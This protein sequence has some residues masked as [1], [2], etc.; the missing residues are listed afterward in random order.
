MQLLI[1]T[2]VVDER[3]PYLSFF[4]AWIRELAKHTDRIEVICLKKGEYSLPENVRVHSLGK[5]SSHGS[6]LVVRAQYVLRFFGLIWGLRKSYDTVL[7]HMNQEY[8]LL[9][10]LLWLLEGKRIFMWRNHYA[11]TSITRIATTLCTKVFCTSRYSYTARF[12]KTVIMPVGVDT[13][14]FKP[15][16]GERKPRTLVS[17]GRV[18]PSK[19]INLLLEALH[20]LH[21]QPIPVT[22]TIY[23]DALPGDIEYVESLKE[24]V[25]RLHL[26]EEVTFR[27]GVAH[28]EAPGVFAAHEVAINLSRS[29][30]LD[31]T[32]F[33]AAACECLVLAVSDDYKTLVDSRLHMSEDPG[34]IAETLR[35]L[36][37]LP[38][39]ERA[40]MGQA[41]RTMVE[42]KH[43]LQS[44]GRKLIHEMS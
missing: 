41:L 17:F 36:L 33:E 15:G 2:Q 43:S 14:M 39:D 16:L 22:T 21:R 35:A 12:R 20:V 38:A 29:G 42:E 37:A 4:V 18:A 25:T 6:Y 27:P 30:M 10:G 7:V 11:G 26:Q 3:D 13:E 34:E 24:M 8:V 32:I 5:E 19:R 44:L 23:G 31:K 9:G 1:T 40:R 28:T